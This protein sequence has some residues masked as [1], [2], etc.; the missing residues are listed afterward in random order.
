MTR[1]G[2]KRITTLLFDLDE[3]LYQPETGLLKQIDRRIEGF[4]Q[5]KLGMDKSAGAELRRKYY[6]QYGTT[7]RGLKEAHG[8]D[9]QEYCAYT[10]QLDVGKYLKPNPVLYEILMRIP[11][12][13]VVFSNSPRR[14]VYRVLQ[15]LQIHQ[16]FSQIFDIEFT[17]YLGKPHLLSYEMVLESLGVS[18]HECILLDDQPVNLEPARELGIITVL[19]GKEAKKNTTVDYKIEVVEEIAEVWADITGKK[20]KKTGS[21]L[22]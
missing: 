14:H 2:G 13:K 22:L 4:L 8:V 5:K 3:T 18:G 12:Q 9:P 19:V 7:L 15:T 11:A 21:D 6:S 17:N 1:S 16:C 20:L 10:Y